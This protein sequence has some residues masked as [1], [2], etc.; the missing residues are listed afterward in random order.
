MGGGGS[1]QDCGKKE[2][3]FPLLLHL[4]PSGVNKGSPTGPSL[5]LLRMLGIPKLD[6]Q[7]GLMD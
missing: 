4:P 5:P 2:T 3:P 1:R 6:V 7:A